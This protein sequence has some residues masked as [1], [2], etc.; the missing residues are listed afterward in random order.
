MNSCKTTLANELIELVFLIWVRSNDN[1][2]QY[3]NPPLSSIMI[4][5]TKMMS[6][7]MLEKAEAPK[8]ICA[9]FVSPLFFIKI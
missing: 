8:M 5:Y 6:F 3:F 4:F 2:G 7:S 1:F 9:I